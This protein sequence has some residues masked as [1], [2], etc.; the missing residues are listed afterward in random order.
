[1]SVS[2]KTS[3]A[4]ICNGFDPKPSKEQKESKECNEAKEAKPS[5]EG[6]LS[7]ESVGWLFVKKYYSTYATAIESLYSFYDGNAS[8]LHDGFPTSSNEND[9]K[10]AK[11]VHV[12]S[13]NDAIKAYYEEQANGTEKSK[14]VIESADFQLSIEGGILIVVCGSWKRGSSNLWH[15]LQTFVLS[16]KG[17]TVYD[18]SNDVLRFFDLSEDYKEKKVIVNRVEPSVQKTIDYVDE[19]KPELDGDNE[20]ESKESI[21][22][23]VSVPSTTATVPSAA[24]PVPSTSELEG[25]EKSE[26]ENKK[27]T[28]DVS[29][30]S[31]TQAPPAE[32]TKPVEVEQSVSSEDEKPTLPAAKQTWANLAAIEPKISSKVASVPASTTVVKS[33]PSPAA[34]KATS[35]SQQPTSTNGS[36]FKKEEWYPIYIKHV[37]VDDEELKSVL[38]KLFG[39]I[40]FYKR[41][42]KAAL[43]DFKHKADQQKALEAKEIVVK[44]NVILLEP[45]VHKPFNNYKQDGKKDK[46]PIKKNGIKKI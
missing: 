3:K 29:S 33:T 24:V 45:R 16:A 30:A 5:K 18:V 21:S 6:E 32:D 2:D 46:K 9:C 25:S 27:E 26:T 34:T 42:N 37:E 39:E 43:C 15:F 40:K 4:P 28:V 31:L 12:A 38:I 22:T 8:L 10:D 1:M 17:E 19:A 13:G 23:E 35:P 36:K 41:S 11:T 7:I 44:G 20:I 14:I